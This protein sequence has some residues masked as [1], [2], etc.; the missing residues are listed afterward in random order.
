M[1][2]C[3]GVRGQ[4]FSRGCGLCAVHWRMCVQLLEVLLLL[5]LLLPECRMLCVGGGKARPGPRGPHGCG[6]GSVEVWTP[7]DLVWRWMPWKAI[8][9]ARRRGGETQCV[10]AG[11]RRPG[12]VVGWEGGCR[13]E[14]W[15]GRRTEGTLAGPQQ[16]RRRLALLVELIWHVGA[17]RYV[18]RLIQRPLAGCSCGCEG[19][20]LVRGRARGQG[21]C[22]RG[23]A[24]PS[25]GRRAHSDLGPL[26]TESRYKIQHGMRLAAEGALSCAS[27]THEPLTSTRWA[28]APFTSWT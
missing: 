27:A 3:S 22:R 19:R 24:S 9:M 26:A 7:Q 11:H 2:G 10:G 16:L 4:R 23:S 6:R 12:A 1:G 14:R 25:R 28:P 21:R 17:C 8:M 15:G 13:S 20:P 5:L 18:M